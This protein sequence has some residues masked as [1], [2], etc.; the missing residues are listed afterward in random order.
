M[1]FSNLLFPPFAAIADTIASAACKLNI[2][3][4]NFAAAYMAAQTIIPQSKNCQSAFV[5]RIRSQLA[6]IGIS[7]RK[8]TAKK[9]NASRPAI[10]RNPAANA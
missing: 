3:Q 10:S 8:E 9:Y 5:F 4:K 2:P 6:A 1:A 7:S